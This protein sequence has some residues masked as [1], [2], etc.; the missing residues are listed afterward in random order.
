MFK[1][2]KNPHTYTL[3]DNIGNLCTTS[4]FVIDILI[5]HPTV[6][7]LQASKIYDI[8]RNEEASLNFLYLEINI[9]MKLKEH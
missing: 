8:Y 3:R 4:R 6:S 7:L 2:F 1:A 5:R 9:K